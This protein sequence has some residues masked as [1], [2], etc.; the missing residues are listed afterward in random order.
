MKHMLQRVMTI[1]IISADVR[2]AAK[3]NVTSTVKQDS[4]LSPIIT[5]AWVRVI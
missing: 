2:S 4:D 5:R 1:A 3:A